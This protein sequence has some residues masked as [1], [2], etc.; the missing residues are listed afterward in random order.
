MK[1]M[2]VC[3]AAC[4]ALLA[5]CS[6]GSSDGRVPVN[7]APEITAIAD[8][9]TVANQTSGPIAF[10]V[11]DE[12]VGG[13]SISVTSDRQQVV[14][15]DGLA[16]AGNGSARS[17]TVTPVGDVTGDAFITVVVTDSAGLS[18]SASFLLTVN[19]E[20]KSMQQF[21]R[22]TFAMDADGEPELINAVEFSMDAEADDFADLL[23]Q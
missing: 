22:G 13:L 20:Q 18:A 21:A 4:G 3:L 9:N 2:Y 15:D 23:G 11:T 16:Q 1:T 19:P 6:G 8:Q 7:Q 14:P 5:G 10:T 17:I 12:Q